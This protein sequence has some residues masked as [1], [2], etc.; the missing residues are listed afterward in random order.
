MPPDEYHQNLE[1]VYAAASAGLAVGGKLLWVPTTP[2]G[3]NSY[4]IEN[5]C[6]RQY[7]AIANKTLGPKPD[8]V[9]GDL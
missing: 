9:I 7:N 3:S 5:S 1:T 8:V 2:T 6:V 4:Q